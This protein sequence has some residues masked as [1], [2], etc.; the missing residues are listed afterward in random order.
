MEEVVIYQ[1]KVKFIRPCENLG[2]SSGYIKRET[3]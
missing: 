2:I 3:D 1:L